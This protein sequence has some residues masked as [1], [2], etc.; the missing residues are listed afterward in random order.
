MYCSDK[1]NQWVPKVVENSYSYKSPKNNAWF[2]RKSLQ[3]TFFAEF[4]Q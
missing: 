1:N 4:S 2:S 3:N